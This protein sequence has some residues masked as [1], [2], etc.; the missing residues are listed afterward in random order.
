MQSRT[1]VRL[2]LLPLVRPQSSIYSPSGSHQ[3]SVTPWGS[4]APAAPG[5]RTPGCNHPSGS[6]S[7]T[8]T[9]AQASPLSPGP[10][11]HPASPT[12]DPRVR[13]TA[14]R[15]ICAA[16]FVSLR[17]LGKALPLPYLCACGVGARHVPFQRVL[18]A[19]A[20]HHIQL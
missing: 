10:P 14:L 7:H 6:L 13:D 8:Q 17:S 15:V 20:N 18:R 2:N 12:G 5:N 4:R 1:S 19:L 9:Q 16:R 3:P 11:A